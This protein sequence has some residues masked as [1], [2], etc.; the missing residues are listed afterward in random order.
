MARNTIPVVFN[1]VSKEALADAGIT[2]GHL[3][4][5][6]ATGVKVN[7]T[8]KDASPQNM[9]AREDELQGKTINDAY[10]A[11]NR[12]LFDIYQPGDEVNALIKIGDSTVAGVTKLESAGNGTL[13]IA[14][15][16]KVIAIALETVTGGASA[17]RCVVEIL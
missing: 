7:A 8:A 1:G 4:E 3:I 10:V 9:F 2:P 6:T 15:T 16:G 5:R 12:V 17:L 14:T 13:Q 11:T